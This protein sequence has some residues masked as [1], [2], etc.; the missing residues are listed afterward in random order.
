MARKGGKDRGLF[1]RSKG[2][3]IWWICYFDQEGQKHRVP[4]GL[5]AGQ[6]DERAGSKLGCRQEAVATHQRGNRE[7]QANEDAR[8]DPRRD[9][10][11]G[12]RPHYSETSMQDEVSRKSYADPLRPFAIGRKRA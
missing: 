7:R 4:Q 11:R 12:Q 9:L 8:D 3:G 1:E 10:A 6:P 5:E 2:S